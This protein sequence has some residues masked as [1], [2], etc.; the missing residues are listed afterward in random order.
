MFEAP[1][2]LAAAGMPAEMRA[3]THRRRA[4]F[5]VLRLIAAAAAQFALAAAWMRGAITVTTMC[6]LH[7]A[8]SFLATIGPAAAFRRVNAR[9]A[10]ELL[11][12]SM[13]GPFGAVALLIERP[14]SQVHRIR[15]TAAAAVVSG[16]SRA[17][18]VTAA[19]RQGRRLQA[20]LVP[21]VPFTNLLAGADRQSQNVALRAISR[22]YHP[23]ML[24][25]L[26]AALG[27]EMP[28][29]RV[30]AAA[31]YGKLSGTF[32]GRARA[33]ISAGVAI[34]DR[35]EASSRAADCRETAASGFV[36]ST[37][38]ETL[39]GLAAVLDALERA[40]RRKFGRPDLI[41]QR[42]SLI[43]ESRPDRLLAQ[44]RLKRH[45]CGGIAS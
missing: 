24:P 27:S 5:R 18:A 13:L 16:A 28:A 29:V 8:V 39:L 32:G 34:A 1:G 17:D 21:S 9:A 38:A 7:V 44:P 23:R 12:L 25:A 42:V 40:E 35:A 15:E 45:A 31:V 10:A 41:R 19:I 2:D 6:E 26:M 14:R 11:M 3:P 4:T 22:N 20:H 30:Q 43:G 33:L 37:T 36:D